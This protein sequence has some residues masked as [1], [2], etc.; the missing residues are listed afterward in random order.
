MKLSEY[1]ERL[2]EIARAEEKQGRDPE[3]VC[4]RFSDY[5]TH[6]DDP[7]W[8]NTSGGISVPR[9]IELTEV[10]GGEYLREVH[11]S[12]RAGLSSPIYPRPGTVK[13]YVELV[14]GN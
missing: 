7:F 2:Q 14:V 12:E 1:I 11:P 8:P 3:V 10:N 9:V 6:I 5:T 13:T 4:R